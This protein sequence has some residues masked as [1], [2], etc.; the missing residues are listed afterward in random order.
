MVNDLQKAMERYW[1]LLGIGP[2]RVF[3]MEPPF[4]TGTTLRGKKRPY[5]MKLALAEIGDVQW[6]LVQP[7]EGPSIY[8]RV[9]H[10][11]K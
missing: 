11:F 4:M 1:H 7:L 8:K 2:W 10:E 3:N 9:L 6:E 5:T